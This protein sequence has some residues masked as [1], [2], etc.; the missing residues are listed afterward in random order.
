MKKLF[1]LAT[2]FLIA[3]LSGCS[4]NLLTVGASHGMCDSAGC[5]YTYAGVCNNVIYIYKHRHE[6]V[7]KR[8]KFSY[9]GKNEGP[10]I[11]P[12]KSSE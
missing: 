9:F 7:D 12:K 6:L 1:F 11:P 3:L 4:G 8:Y 10:Y 2:P 5:N